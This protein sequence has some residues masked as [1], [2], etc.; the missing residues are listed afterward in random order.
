MERTTNLLTN[1][2]LV[3]G[4]AAS[5]P[6]GWVQETSG[7]LCQTLEVGTGKILRP[8]ET[9]VLEGSRGSS[10]SSATVELHDGTSCS[11]SSSSSIRFTSVTT[12]DFSGGRFQAPYETSAT[13][14]SIALRSSTNAWDMWTAVKLFRVLCTV[15]LGFTKEVATLMC[16]FFFFSLSWSTVD[17][18]MCRSCDLTHK[19]FE[20]HLFFFF[21]MVPM[22]LVLSWTTLSITTT[23][24][25]LRLDR[26]L[27]MAIHMQDKWLT[28][29]QQVLVELTT[30]IVMLFTKMGIA[31]GTRR[32][33]KTYEN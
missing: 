11:S 25:K 7:V 4:S 23:Q 10:S 6:D 33:A 27:M 24:E 12:G 9:L 32:P 17:P 28:Q 18:D 14:V 5:L 8:G 22:G 15:D 1:P 21:Q 31:A 26:I 3:I 16:E 19:T 29:R 13:S 30:V 2:T 20:F